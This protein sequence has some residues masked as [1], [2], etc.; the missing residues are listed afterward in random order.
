[1]PGKD[2]ASA[3]MTSHTPFTR[4]LRWENCRIFSGSMEKT[5]IIIITY[6]VTGRLSTQVSSSGSEL[7]VIICGTYKAYS[8]LPTFDG[9][10]AEWR[11]RR[12]RLLWGQGSQ[13]DMDVAG[14]QSVYFL[15]GVL[16]W[17]M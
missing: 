15:C 14:H 4:L 13:S 5:R 1:M 9:Q 7:C 12:R 10:L 11:R 8:Y 6:Y 17:N 2:V 3:Q 16:T